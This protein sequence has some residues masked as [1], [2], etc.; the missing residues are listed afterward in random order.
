MTIPPPQRPLK[1]VVFDLD[2]L[3]FNSEDV[4]ELMGQEILRRRGKT[5]DDEL[6]ERIMGR[7]AAISLQTIIEWYGLDDT[8]DDLNLESDLVFA[9]FLGS[10]LAL[11]PGSL[12]LLQALEAAGIPKAIATSSSRNYAHDLLGRFELVHRFS[13]ILTADDVVNGKPSPEVYALAAAR[14]GVV[15]AEMMVL[16]DSG[17]GCRAAV[18]AGAYTV[19]VPNQHTA[20]HDFTGV[21]FIADSLDDPRIRAALNLHVPG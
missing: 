7:P 18:A 21:R 11:M 19:A 4:Y 2:G 6:R 10:V 20:R 3:L 16:E 8:I 12:A 5:M 15:P 1:S 14:L 13:P 17:N 9:E